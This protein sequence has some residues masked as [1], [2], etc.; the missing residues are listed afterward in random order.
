MKIAILALAPRTTHSAQAREDLARLLQADGRHVLQQPEGGPSQW[1]TALDRDAPDVLLLESG[2]NPDQALELAALVSARQPALALLLVS[3]DQTPDF[4]LRA[5]RAGV[6]EVL[7]APTTEVEL[8]SALRRVESKLGIPAR[9]G[10][11]LAFVG[12][13]GGAGATFLATNLGFQLAQDK[14]VLLIDLNLQFGDALAF[15]HD[16]L[17]QLTLAD[18]AANIARMDANYLAASSVRVAPNFSVLA[19]PQDAG[20]AMEIKPEHVQAILALACTMHDFVLLDV[21]RR[22][23][24]LTIRALDRADRIYPVLQADLAGMRNAG[25]FLAGC[26]ALNYPTERIELVLNRYERSSEL[27]LA[28]IRRAFGNVA[29]RTVPNGYREVNAAL[30]R[31][32]ALLQVAR[33]SA[34]ARQLGEFAASLS[35]KLAV[36]GGLL[37][38]LLRRA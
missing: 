37:D 6:R 24:P 7:P 26:R 4:L 33:G 35:P 30:N 31:G 10:Q 17:P 8:Q 9:Q 28:D 22:F 11:V 38:R 32:N 14:S 27:S 5:M 2:G 36:G 21:P 15:V 34:V 20:Q 1:L 29:L 16:E 19:A 18:V 3:P 25:R 23:D 12:C 13:K